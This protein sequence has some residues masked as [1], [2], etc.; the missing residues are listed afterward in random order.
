MNGYRI[1]IDL[2][3]KLKENGCSL[4]TKNKI[5][6]SNGDDCNCYFIFDILFD[7]CVKYAKEF[8]G[9]E[10]INLDLCKCNRVWSAWTY[11]TM[12]EDDFEETFEIA[13]LYHPKIII[14]MLQNDTDIEEIEDYIWKNCVFNKE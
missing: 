14:E 3:R 1:S 13:H 6:I 12:S 5:T 9:T 10:Y 7:I 11:G 8:F 2:A 4:E